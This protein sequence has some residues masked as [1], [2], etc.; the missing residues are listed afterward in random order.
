MTDAGGFRVRETDWARDGERLA[1][2]RTVVFIDEQQVPPDEE[3]DGRDPD[4]AHVVAETPDGAVIGTGR[5]LPD[6]HIG[7]MAVAASWRGR[8][9]GRA[10]LEALLACARA[11]GFASV[12]LNAQTTAIGF[13]ERC[14]FRA[15]GPE[16]ED[17]GILHRVMRRTLEGEAS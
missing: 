1:A 3:H 15:E 9:V 16:F 17:A 10:L 6:G 14:G 7:R 12:E 2:L 5:L 8:G 4:C 11:R 13:Y